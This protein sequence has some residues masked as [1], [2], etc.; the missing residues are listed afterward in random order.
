MN[1][2]Y[3]K[4]ELL[5]EDI[6]ASL[7]ESI[8]VSARKREHHPFSASKLQAVEACVGFTGNDS[9]NE[10]S[11]AGTVQHYAMDTGDLRCLDDYQRVVVRGLA[12]YR[13]QIVAKFKTDYGANSKVFIEK[14]VR[15]DDEQ[16]A[17][18]AV[19]TSGGFLDLALVSESG[20]HARVH[21]W[22]FG[23]WEIEPT[24]TNLQGYVYALGI[25]RQFPLLESVTVEFDMPYL[26]TKDE[27]TF[28]QAD[29]PRMYAR[30]KLAVARRL[31]A[32]KLPAGKRGMVV[33]DLVCC[34][35]GNMA[36]C[37]AIAKD[38]LNISA[39]YAPMHVPANVLPSVITDPM[40]ASAGMKYAR[41]MTAWGKGYS[42]QCALK[43]VEDP[44]FMPEGFQ[45]VTRA[46]RNIADMPR[47]EATL[48]GLGI[49]REQ[50]QNAKTLTLT[51]STKLVRATAARGSKD[52]TE[53]AFFEAAEVAG[54]IGR[55]DTITFLQA[56]REKLDE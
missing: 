34:F 6:R 33:R 45:I 20:L 5:D 51:A 15:V 28:T 42:S 29:F 36:T 53:K 48:S 35:C 50:I 47:F 18:D 43:A 49:S 26:K 40:Q 4:K 31:E 32:E 23:R 10:A 8:L 9:E 24:V 56:K 41:L 14:N 44:A 3:V 37:P 11:A 21:D 30:V 25:L 12:G 54:M 39:K 22:K 16:P 52:E 27:H 17:P 2:E 46:D 13:D 1:P 38:V 19:G 55:E 7:V